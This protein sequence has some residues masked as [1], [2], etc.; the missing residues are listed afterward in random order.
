MLVVK[1][2]GERDIHERLA[3]PGQ[4][5]RIGHDGLWQGLKRANQPVVGRVVRSYKLGRRAI[6]VVAADPVVD[7]VVIVELCGPG[8]WWIRL[9]PRCGLEARDRPI[10]PAEQVAREVTEAPLPIGPG[11][12]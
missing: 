9:G 12:A 1:V 6:G 7:R 5:V 4:R 10:S 11:S 8:R 3:D 2:V